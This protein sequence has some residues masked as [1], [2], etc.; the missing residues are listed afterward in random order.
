MDPDL[1]REDE[2]VRFE[3][4]TRI[5]HWVLAAPF[6]LLLLTGLTNFIPSLKAT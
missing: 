6:V 4:P 5:V 2:V 1:V 3:R